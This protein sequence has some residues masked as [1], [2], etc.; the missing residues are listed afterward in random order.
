MSYI[1]HFIHDAVRE[2]T[3]VYMQNDETSDVVHIFG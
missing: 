2:K 1:H 3:S